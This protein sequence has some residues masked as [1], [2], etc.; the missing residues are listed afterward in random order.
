MEL[1]TALVLGFLGSFHCVGMCG[2]I[3]L[4]IPRTSSRLLS[5]SSNA[6]IYNFG[7]V[8][9]Y[10]LFGLLFGFLGRGITL[11][12]FQSW[13]SIAL[14]ASILI[15]VIFPRF[16]RNRAKPKFYHNFVHLITTAYGKLLRRNSK[17]SLFGMGVLNG[18]LP[19]AFVY[20]GLSA[21]VLTNTPLHSMAY[22]ALFGLGTIP[23]M[24]SIYLA[25]SF[26]SLDLR[27][28]IRKYLP[29]L[30]F[31]LGVFLIIRGIALQ[32]LHLTGLLRER[33]DAFCIFPGT[34]S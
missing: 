5:L 15:A 3:A 24:F 13:L 34:G 22:M 6:L 20:T 7:R 14:G 26:I 29:Y 21:A 19:C 1:W 27:S 16:F 18:L 9:T 8:L 32:D 2:P 23:A 28:A 12:G 33:I 10:S 30:A 17:T 25:P 4:S 11:S 31:S